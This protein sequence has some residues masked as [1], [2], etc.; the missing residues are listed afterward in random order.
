MKTFIYI[1]LL[2]VP[3]LAW[4]CGSEDGSSGN[5]QQQVEYSPE[6]DIDIQRYN[7]AAERKLSG[8]SSPCDTFA[9]AEHILNTYP[10]GSYLVP[11]DKTTSF[12]IPKHAVIYLRDGYILALVATSRAGE[13]LIELKNVVGYDQ[14]FID[15]DSTKLGTAFFYLTLFDCSSG[16][17]EMVWEKPVPNHG[18]FNNFSVERWTYKRT[19]YVRINFHYARG[20]GHINYNYFAIDGWENEPHLLMTYLGINFRR[21]I[22]NNNNDEFPDYYEYAFY[23]FQDRITVVDSIPFIWDVKQNV[24]VNTRNKRQTRLY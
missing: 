7:V 1:L 3:L 17:F 15:L 16:S 9:L 4:G 23:D 11:F 2:I 8:E 10:A 12:S 6:K 22:A 21:T 18:G 20:I 19:P 24:Y 14:S 5:S 13:R